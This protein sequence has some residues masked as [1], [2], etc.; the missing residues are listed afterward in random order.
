MTYEKYC[1]IKFAI[2]ENYQFV[3]TTYN[4]LSQKLKFGLRIHV[5]GY[6]SCCVIER[7][8]SDDNN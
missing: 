5:N 8:T 4:A 7:L 2:G 1:R 6:V 3:E